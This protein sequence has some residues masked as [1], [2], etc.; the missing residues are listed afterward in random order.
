VSRLAALASQAA[1]WLLDPAAESA[2]RVPEPADPPTVRSLPSAIRSFGSPAPKTPD[3]SPLAARPIVA[4][5][6]LLPGC[7]ATTV[8]RALAATLARR[9]HS[10]AAILSASGEPER[11]ALA[12]PAA[13]RLAGRIGAGAHAAGRLCIADEPSPLLSRL[14]PLVLD[15]PHG[16]TPSLPPDLTVLVVPGSAEPALAELAAQ[17]LGEPLSVVNRAAD[18][19]RWHPR[20]FAQLPHSRLAVRLAGA[21]WEPRGAFGAAIAKIADACEEA[22]CA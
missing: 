9:D 17:A 15:V 22:G 16:A 4:I 14:A 13:S 8:A 2:P 10:G 20:A 3:G 7:G 11:S 6:G 5:V 18:A 1:G 19:G 12:V 21:G